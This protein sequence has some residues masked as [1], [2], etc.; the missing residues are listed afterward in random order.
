MKSFKKVVLGLVAAMAV[1]SAQA[2]VSTLQANLKKNYPATKVTSVDV[3]PIKGIYEVVLGK[4]LTYTDETGEYF[5][6]GDIIRMKDQSNLSS[7]KR[8][9]LKKIDFNSLPFK[10][11]ITYKRGDGSRKLAV[12]SDPQCPFCKR[13]ETELM[14]LDNVTIYVFTNPLV[15][16]HPEARNLSKKIWCSKDKQ[17]AWRDYLI[18]SIEPTSDGLCVNP[19]DSNIQLSR[20]L[21]FD[22]TPMT[23]LEDGTVVAGAVSVGELDYKLDKVAIAKANKK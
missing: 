16:L 13:L 23:I 14:K 18:S 4:N 10:D 9:E 15:G 21:G 22:G 20:E 7:Q 1:V 8:D 2:D 19:V 6:F 5:L 3:T 12:F 17:K 11:A